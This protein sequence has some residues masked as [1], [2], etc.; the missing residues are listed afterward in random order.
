MNILQQIRE[1][2]ND[3]LPLADRLY[4]DLLRDI[5][6]GDLPRGQWRELTGEELRKLQAYL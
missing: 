5:L 1:E 3:V 2:K 4:F 6:L